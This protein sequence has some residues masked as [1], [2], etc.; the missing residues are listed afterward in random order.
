MNNLSYMINGPGVQGRLN[1]FRL[2]CSVQVNVT[3]PNATFV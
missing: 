2:C 3:L 1:D